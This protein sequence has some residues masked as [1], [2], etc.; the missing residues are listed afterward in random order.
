MDYT[1]NSKK[2]IDK[3]M[4]QNKKRKEGSIS[5]NKKAIYKTF[6]VPTVLATVMT[7]KEG[8]LLLVVLQIPSAMAFAWITRTLHS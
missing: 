2:A 8:W 5:I 4:S 3:N 6:F 7:Y 1:A